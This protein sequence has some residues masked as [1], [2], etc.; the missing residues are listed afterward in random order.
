MA[1]PLAAA[2]PLAVATPPPS[3]TANFARLPADRR[4]LLPQ[5]FAETPATSLVPTTTPPASPPAD[6]IATLQEAALAQNDFAAM[7]AALDFATAAAAQTRLQTEMNAQAAD[8]AAKIRYQELQM[9]MMAAEHKADMERLMTAAAHNTDMERMKHEMQLTAAHAAAAAVAGAQAAAAQA[10][11]IAAAVSS[12][13]FAK[14]HAKIIAAHLLKHSV[15]TAFTDQRIHH[16]STIAEIDAIV[17]AMLNTL[18]VVPGQLEFSLLLAIIFGLPCQHIIVEPDSITERN[19]QHIIE[20]LAGAAGG[21]DAIDDDTCSSSSSSSRQSPRIDIFGSSQHRQ[22]YAEL[23]RL[24]A[25]NEVPA[26]LSSIEYWKGM[27]QGLLGLIKD[28]VP[29]TTPYMYNKV[30]SQSS[31]MAA[32]QWIL[33]LR[34]QSM[35][36]QLTDCVKDLLGSHDYTGHDGSYD[37]IPASAIMH[38]LIADLKKRS[39]ACKTVAENQPAFCLSKALEFLPSFRGGELEHVFHDLKQV[40]NTLAEDSAPMEDYIGAIN[41][42]ISKLGPDDLTGDMRA[43]SPPKKLFADKA[44]EPAMAAVL[45]VRGGGKSKGKGPAAKPTAAVL[46]PIPAA[47]AER[48]PCLAGDQCPFFGTHEPCVQM[49]T[50]EQMDAMRKRLGPK[51]VNAD[52]RR[53]RQIQT[54][55]AALKM[56]PIPDAKNAAAEAAEIAR[57][58]ATC[59]AQGQPVAAQPAAAAPTLADQIEKGNKLFLQLRAAQANH[60]QDGSVPSGAAFTSVPHIAM[61]S[62]GRVP[63]KEPSDSLDAVIPPGQPPTINNFYYITLPIAESPP[64]AARGD[65]CFGDFPACKAVLPQGDRCKTGAAQ[66]NTC[67]SVTIDSPGTGGRHTAT[68]DLDSWADDAPRSPGRALRPCE[69]HRLQQANRAS[70]SHSSER[71]QP[72]CFQC[73]YSLPRH[74][75]DGSRSGRC[76]IF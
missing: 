75:A 38:G 25:A 22:A 20:V 71:M 43:P 68:D 17:L 13:P 48:G 58:I 41:T 49:H 15:S 62:V 14:D 9:M 16:G 53:L 5:L 35:R 11:S 42:A 61:C 37:D 7:Q 46:P 3:P 66:S 27:D 39:R 56:K 29:A 52:D 55:D 2:T 26:S 57:A 51:Y 30:Q 23:A 40:L 34:G 47:Q 36:R 67:A 73:P 76:N 4:S 28:K 74:T 19:V 69:Y 31:F 59:M 24:F 65:L 33:F 54:V 12:R 10:N 64:I 6:G 21:A 72:H 32:L 44:A 45:P 18:S 8:S 60:P 1:A 50:K 70:A 63:A